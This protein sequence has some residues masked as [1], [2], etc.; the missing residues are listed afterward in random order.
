MFKIEMSSSVNTYL[1]EYVSEEEQIILAK[2]EYLNQK[3]AKEY[4][5][6]P[7]NLDNVLVLNK[8]IFKY[9]NQLTQIKVKSYDDKRKEEDKKYSTFEEIGKKYDGYV[10]DEMAKQLDKELRIKLNIFSEEEDESTPLSSEELRKQAAAKKRIED[11]NKRRAA[12][13]NIYEKYEKENNTT[14]E[15]KYDFKKEREN[16]KAIRDKIE[17]EKKIS[18]EDKYSANTIDI[19]DELYTTYCKDR[20]DDSDEDDEDTKSKSCDIVQCSKCVSESEYKPLYSERKISKLSA[21]DA[22]KKSK[23]IADDYIFNNEQ[24]SVINSNSDYFNISY[25]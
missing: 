1:D 12:V 13:D 4:E 8:M 3:I 22:I 18:K 25:Y 15:H 5:V 7:V 11:F 9:R 20:K 2:I 14:E 21:E 6:P 16:V 17:K 19:K 10:D 24:I 23:R